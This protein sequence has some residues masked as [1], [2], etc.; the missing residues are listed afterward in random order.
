MRIVVVGSGTIGKAVQ[1]TLAE[2][3]HT[4]VPVGR[5]SG[6]FQADMTDMESLRALFARIGAFDAVACAAGDVFP[7]PLEETTDEQWAKSLAAKGMGQINLVR[8]A[9]PH[10]ADRGSFTLVSG[11]L[12]DEVMWAGTIGTTI[13]HLV[14]GFVKGAAAEMQRG[15]RINCVSPTVLAESVAYHAYFTG[16]TPVPVSDVALAYLR[17]ISTPL[18]GRVLKLHKTDS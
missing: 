2:A 17:A 7:A 14:E 8:A 5:D 11:V 15:I 6:E 9:L 3:G 4:I 1:A 10:I 18:N 13:N 12:T 16:F